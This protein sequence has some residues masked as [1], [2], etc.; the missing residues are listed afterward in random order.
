M[1]YDM[2]MCDWEEIDALLYYPG[3]VECDGKTYNYKLKD[4]KQ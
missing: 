1:S 3:C 4:K 2:E